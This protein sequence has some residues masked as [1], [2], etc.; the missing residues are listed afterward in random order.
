MPKKEDIRAPSEERMIREIPIDKIDPF[1]DHPY[2]VL[3]N[4]DM[5][6]LTESIR[7][8]GVIT[9]LLVRKMYHGRFELVS[10][11]RR[12]H[13]CKKL[14]MKSVIC[15]VREMSKEE[16][17]ITMVESNFQRDRLLPSEKAFA[18]KMRLDAMKFH[19][20][21]MRENEKQGRDFGKKPVGPQIEAASE[22]LAKAY[23]LS[24]REVDAIG[25][26]LSV[27]RNRLVFLA[28]STLLVSD[29]AGKIDVLDRKSVALDVV[30]QRTP[31]TG[32]FMSMFCIYVSDRLPLHDE[33]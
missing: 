13:A 10:G 23:G 1:P 4:E 12:L 11:H 33:W 21:R 26:I 22:H 31:A 6:Q 25:A 24:R 16:A 7:A 5:E 3:D 2:K 15:E 18:Y 29:L 30:V 9:P 8:K 14:G 32:Q 27:L 20:S 28:L 19:I 17:I